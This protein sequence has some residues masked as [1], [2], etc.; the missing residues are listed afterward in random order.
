M[1]KVDLKKVDLNLLVALD[2]LLR[3]QSVTRAG[4]RIG[5]SQPAM[6]RALARLRTLFGDPLLVASGRRLVPT[7]RALDLADR[8]AHALETV[9]DLLDTT[10]F[11]PAT[12]DTAFRINAPDATV[13]LLLSEVLART[14]VTA[15]GITFT[16]HSAASGQLEGLDRGDLDLAI[17]TFID[18]PDRFC[19]QSLYENRLVCVL[20]RG[21]PALDKPFGK[22]D[23]SAWPH[24]WID[25]ATSRAF[26]LMLER[27][28]VKRTCAVRITSFM[29][30]ATV[31]AR[32]DYL[33]V[34]PVLVAARACELL[35]LE[36]LELPFRIQR[37]TLDQL[38][39]PRCQHDPA[40]EWL[41]TMIFKI[42]QT[43][44]PPV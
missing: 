3:E 10:A 8:L 32:T 22:K 15:P 36:T 24:V 17:D 29:T 1:H 31:A 25:S 12:A 33:L 18:A 37:L 44:L 42:A 39:H 11:D 21:H 13:M 43:S 38:W 6:S 2:A 9:G 41:R 26:D 23:F 20:R 35:P 7:P 16:I 14:A 34:L 5:R 40:H 19:R 30:G 4:E 28:G 27:Q